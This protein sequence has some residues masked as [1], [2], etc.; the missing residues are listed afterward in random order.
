MTTAAADISTFLYCM[1]I[2]LIGIDFSCFVEIERIR[3][4]IIL[5]PMKHFESRALKTCPE[6]PDSNAENLKLLAP[7]EAPRGRLPPCLNPV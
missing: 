7:R 1:N 6:N 4:F 5:I 2:P 3:F